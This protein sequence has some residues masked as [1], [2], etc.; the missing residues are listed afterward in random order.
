MKIRRISSAVVVLAFALLFLLLPGCGAGSRLAIDNGSAS[1]GGVTVTLKTA[2]ARRMTN[3]DRYEYSFSGTIENNSDEGIM[4]VVYSFALYDRNGG[5]YR[6]F[7]E[8]YDGVDRAIPPHSAVPFSHEGIRWGAQSVPASVSIG[9]G[10]VLTETELPPA[11]IPQPGEYLYQALGNEKLADIRENPPAALS[12]HVDQGGYGRTAV[13]SGGE[14]LSTAVRL[15]C[16]I[17]I[18]E[19]T[20][21]WVTDNYNWIGLTWEDGSETCISLNLR[22][23]EYSIHSSPHTFALENLNEFWSYAAD[24]LE[25]DS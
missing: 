25:E 24:Y 13:F 11:K 18:G 20:E 17:K 4:K 23:L 6:S 3:P 15:F 2:S 22:S 1:N 21:E 9:I 8:V 7:A 12:F 14:A 10:S 19:E 5:K 16:N